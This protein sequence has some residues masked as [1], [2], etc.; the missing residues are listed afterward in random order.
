MPAATY[1]QQTRFAFRHGVT[2]LTGTADAVLTDP[3][4]EEK[5]TGLTAGQLQALETL[6]RGPATLAEMAAGG[7]DVAGL[8]GRLADDG[9]LSITVRDGGRDLY[10][11]RPFTRSAPRPS[12]P[13]PWSAT[14]SK[15]AVLHR[16]SEGFVLEHPRAWCDLRIHD[17]RLLAL[18][19]GLGAADA[20]VPIAVKAQFADD[21]HWC[22][23]L[24]A[25][26]YTEDDEFPQAE[27]ACPLCGSIAAARSANT[28]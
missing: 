12:T 27:G 8:M 22:G 13:L 11:I 15:F 17:P 28:P 14:L 16:D 20:D 18:L 6:N 26:A 4:C 24:V 5:L 9:W 10:T 25:D 19:D 3:P 7:D 21:L 2:C 23:F 1:P